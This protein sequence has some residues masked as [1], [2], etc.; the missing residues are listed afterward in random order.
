MAAGGG[1]GSLE[2]SPITEGGN[3]IRQSVVER[4][5]GRRMLH[6]RRMTRHLAH[7]RFMPREKALCYP[8]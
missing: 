3:H 6:E 2:S 4:A 7:D 1:A 8:G 5:V